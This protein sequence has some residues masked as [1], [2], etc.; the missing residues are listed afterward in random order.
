MTILLLED[1]EY[2]IG[3]FKELYKNQRLFICN[4]I[5]Q[6]KYVCLHNNIDIFQLGHDLDQ[7]QWVNSNEENTGYRFCKWLIENN[8]QKSA[9]CY[10]HSMNFVGASNMMNLMLDNDRDA[11][12]HPY[13][14]LK[15]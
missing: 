8:Y 7:R 5:Q 14:L 9:L 3:R 6:A 13:H 2:R 10:I 11:I 15:I 12:W 1:N 4:N